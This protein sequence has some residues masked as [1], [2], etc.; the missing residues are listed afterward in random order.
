MSIQGDVTRGFVSVRDAFAE[1]FSRR[2]ELGGA[3]CAY[4]HG[5]KIV[6]LGSPERDRG[7]TRSRWGSI[8]ANCC[9]ASVRDIAHPLPMSVH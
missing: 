8:R 6:D 4:A 3:C 2:H 5:E 1:N 7:I 9:V